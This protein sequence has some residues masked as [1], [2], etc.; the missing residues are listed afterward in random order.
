MIFCLCFVLVLK[1]VVKP[2][3]HG[4]GYLPHFDANTL[5]QHVVFHAFDALEGNVFA[6]VCSKPAEIRP[7]LVDQALD[8]SCFGQTFSDCD[9]ADVMQSVLRFFD[10]DRYDLQAWCVMPNHVHVVLVTAPDVLLGQ[11]IKS[12]K[13]AA[14][15][16]INKLRGTSG[17]VFAKDYFDRFMRN[18]KQAETA[19]HYVEA[20]PVKANLC[21]D[22]VDWPWSSAYFKAQGWRPNHDRLP[23][24]LD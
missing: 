4:R 12:W 3:W 20:N 23:L 2:G 11:I 17:P 22:G 15:L 10:G 21:L 24:F 6:Q 8:S 9:C 18:L 16:R 13:Y 5:L 14:A 19:I 1:Q 7:S